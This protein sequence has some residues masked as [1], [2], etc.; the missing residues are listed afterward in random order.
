MDDIRKAATQM[1]SYA[2]NSLMHEIEQ[3]RNFKAFASWVDDG[4]FYER[5]KCEEIGYDDSAI[6]AAKELSKEVEADVERV[7]FLLFGNSSK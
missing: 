2:V 5:L 4:R 3:T 7:I 6:E 1:V